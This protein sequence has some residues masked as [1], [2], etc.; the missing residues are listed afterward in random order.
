MLFEEINPYLRFVRYFELDRTTSYLYHIPYDARFFYAAD[1]NG[2]IEIGGKEYI[3]NKGCLLIIS[4]GIEYHIRTPEQ[5]VRYFAVNFDFTKSCADLKMPIAPQT[6][7]YF[8]S[9]LI[10][11]KVT[12]SDI[13]QFNDY[14]YLTDMFSIENKLK[15]LEKEYS[16]KL[17]SYETKISH[18]FAD[19]LLECAR[20]MI[21]KNYSESNELIESILNYIHVNYSQP[22]TNLE[23]GKVF[24]FHPNYISAIIKN[25]TG[26]P[27]HKYLI[28]IRLEHAII[29]LELGNDSIGK[30]AQK[31]GF[32]DIYYF[33]KYFKKVVGVSPMQYKRK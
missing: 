2:S 1:G 6:S 14:I 27:L 19:I 5:K 21:T 3:M 29:M 22:L 4:P 15:E 18:I 30:I 7:H 25:F 13:P 23:I 16:R 26:L 31:C 9:S 33:S 24:G 17:V 32:C 11:E 28:H 10:T 8:D 20:R 12:F